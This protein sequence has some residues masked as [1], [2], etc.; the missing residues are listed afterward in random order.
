M[1]YI[2]GALF[3]RCLKAYLVTDEDNTDDSSDE[4]DEKIFSD[5]LK[6]ENGK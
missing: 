3:Y 4:E 5:E 6:E 2:N 1:G